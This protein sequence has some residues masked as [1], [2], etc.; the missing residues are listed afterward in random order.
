MALPL[1]GI[2]NLISY[3]QTMQRLR[4]TGIS[5]EEYDRQMSQMQATMNTP[6]YM[7]RFEDGMRNMNYGTVL[8]ESPG[9]IGPQ[10][11]DSI[12]FRAGEAMLPRRLDSVP[13][14][15][16]FTPAQLEA[17]REYVYGTA[18]EVGPQPLVTPGPGGD[19][20]PQGGSSFDT[21][22]ADIEQYLGGGGKDLEREIAYGGGGGGD[23]GDFDYS[24]NAMA[25]GG[26]IYRGRR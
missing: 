2:A 18:P 6:E 3:M 5:E 14:E 20:M 15:S 22:F 13:V 16:N 11:E 7:N 9:F 23:R 10:T 17:L 1:F 25:K 4:D 8:P 19:Y 12:S 26:Q 21:S 24:S